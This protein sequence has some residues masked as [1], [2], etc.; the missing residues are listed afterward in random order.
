MSSESPPPDLASRLR[1]ALRSSAASVEQRIQRI[2]HYRIDHE[3]GSGGMATVYAATDE[4]L[5]RPVAIK[6]MREGLQF[7]AEA[8][9]R[10]QR[11][12][13]AAA[14]IDHPCICPVYE[15]GDFGGVPFIVMRRISGRSL[16]EL[17]ESAKSSS[18]PGNLL[19][20]GTTR[21]VTSVLSLFEDIARALHCAHEAGLVHRDI[22]PA[23]LMIA[24]DGKPDRKSVV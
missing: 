1:Q 9:S 17:V 10:F 8:R 22:K 16:A 18:E 7:S 4:E 13:L 19:A 15:V 2:G 11:E 5:R 23:N 12:A 3:L 14:R 24:D 6:L 20:H 21:S